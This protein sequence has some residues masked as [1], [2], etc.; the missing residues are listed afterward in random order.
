[1]TALRIEPDKRSKIGRKSVCCQLVSPHECIDNI[2]TDNPLHRMRKWIESKGWWTAEMEEELRATQKK[3]VL[4]AFQRGEKLKRPALEHL[5]TDMYAGE[6]PLHLV[7]P[8]TAHC[9]TVLILVPH[10][11]EEKEEL[12]KILKKYGD[13]WKP[14]KTEKT[15]F[16]GEAKEFT[17][18]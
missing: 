8:S 13:V 5:F 14:Y 11:T 9:S 12:R 15:K 1:M 2:A 10:K 18:K 4:A 6:E 7:R 3:D 16:T 17:Q